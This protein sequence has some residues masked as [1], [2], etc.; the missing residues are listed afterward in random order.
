MSTESSITSFGKRRP[1]TSMYILMFAL[2]LIVNT[3][4]KLDYSPAGQSG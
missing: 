4:R 1:L 3:R 2:A